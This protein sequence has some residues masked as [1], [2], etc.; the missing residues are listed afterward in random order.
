MSCRDLR[1]FG[2][3]QEKASHPAQFLFQKEWRRSFLFRFEGIAANQFAQPVRCM[4]RRRFCRAHFV[5]N[6]AHPLAGDL[7]GG[8]RS[9]KPPAYDM[10]FRLHRNQ[11]SI[12]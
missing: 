1:L 2:D 8:F 5:Q 3:A 9:G 10:D 12:G 7:K 11:R 6:R 4:G